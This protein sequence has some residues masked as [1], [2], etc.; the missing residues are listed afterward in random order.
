MTDK[1]EKIEFPYPEEKYTPSN[2]KLISDNIELVG[3][4]NV[5]LSV[6]LGSADLSI[7][8]LFSLTEGETIKLNESLDS[9]IL[10]ELNGKTIAKGNLV[11]VGD[12]FG[13]EIVQIID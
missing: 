4:V 3:H 10:L 8:E 9:P 6:N 1:I 13:I 2:K 7:S 11:A 12:N 5:N